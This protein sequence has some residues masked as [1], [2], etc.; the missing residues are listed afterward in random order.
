MLNTM[1]TFPEYDSALHYF[2]I[3]SLQQKVVRT[4]IVVTFVARVPTASS[5]SQFPNT[6]GRSGSGNLSHTTQIMPSLK[7]QVEVPNQEITTNVA[8]DIAKI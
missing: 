3:S 8:R 6:A 5:A 2:H 1:E 7:N 4:R